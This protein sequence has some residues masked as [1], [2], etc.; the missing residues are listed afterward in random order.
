MAALLR[1]FYN[2]FHS[3][4]LIGVAK[5]VIYNAMTQLYNLLNEGVDLGGRELLLK[6][7]EEVSMLL[8]LLEMI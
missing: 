6:V 2:E 3:N 4:I 1:V 5:Y 7:S 8:L